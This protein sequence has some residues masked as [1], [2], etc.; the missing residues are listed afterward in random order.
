MDLFRARQL[1]NR[2]TD[3]HVHSRKVSTLAQ[4]AAKILKM[5]TSEIAIAGYL[6]DIGKTIWPAELF[7][8]HPLSQA[9]W[10]FIKSHPV[11]GVKIA[12]DILPDIPDF[13]KNLIRFHHERPDG[14]GYPDGLKDLSEEILLLAACDSFDAMTTERAYRPEGAFTVG[15]ALEE[16]GR[17]ATPA[18]VSALSLAIAKKAI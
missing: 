8:K 2:N 10:A 5:P 9:D 1:L 16:I 7:D 11:V 6:H 3:L 13:V 15:Y 4:K 17:F 12:S 18:I 14:K